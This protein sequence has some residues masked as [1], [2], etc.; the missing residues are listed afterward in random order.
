MKLLNALNRLG[1]TNEKR[2]LSKA[3]GLCNRYRNNIHLRK[4]LVSY[5]LAETTSQIMND[6]LGSVAAMPSG[7]AK[8]SELKDLIG[9]AQRTIKKDLK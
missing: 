8:V 1:K 7:P 2:L 6:I 9:I 3:N 5:D 4:P